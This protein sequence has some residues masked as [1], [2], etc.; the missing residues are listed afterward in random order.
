M[1]V[2]L[3]RKSP[4]RRKRAWSSHHKEAKRRPQGEK[5]RESHTLIKGV[6]GRN[7]TTKCLKIEVRP[8]KKT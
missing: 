1:C 4:R 2:D 6:D 7:T 3:K 5:K 8:R